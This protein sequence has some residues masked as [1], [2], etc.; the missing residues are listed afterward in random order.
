MTEKSEIRKQLHDTALKAPS[1]S[2]VYLWR[3]TEGVIIYVGKAKNLKSRLT[4]YFSERNNVKTMLL[5]ANALSIEYITTNNEFDA[6][7]LE[8]NLI[9]Q[10]KPRYNINLKDDK[11]YPSLRITREEFPRIFS[12]RRILRDGSR[13]FG[14]FPNAGALAAFIEALSRTYPL[15]RCRQLRKRESPCMYYHIGSCRAPCCGKINKEAYTEF[16]EE[17]AALLE[18][19]GKKTGKKLEAAMKEAAKSLNFEKAARLRD[20]INAMGF[21]KTGNAVQ[22]FDLDDRDYVSWAAEG[23]LVSFTVLKVR[24]GKLVGRD[25]YR[26]R[27]LSD[28]ADL[29]P[30]FLGA[31]YTGEAEIPP[32]LF[33]PEGNDVALLHSWFTEICNAKPD[34]RCVTPGMADGSRHEAALNMTT[35]NAK[36]DIARR[37][38]EQGD[39]PAM[40]E[41]RRLLN[42]PVL[43]VRIEGFDIAHIGGDLPVASLISFYN[44]NPDKKNYRYFRLKT[45]EGIIDDFA[46]LREAVSRRY[47]RL[48][49][50]QAEFPDL[51]LVDGGIGQVNAV[52]GVLA[53]LKLNIPIVGLAKRDEELYLPGNS[54]PLTVPKRSDALRLLQRVRD[55]THR[56]A[57]SKNQALRTK[58]KIAEMTG[59][60]VQGKKSGA[61]VR[62]N[63]GKPAG[64]LAASLA[65]T[66]LAE[67]ETGK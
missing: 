30:E 31:Y 8:N 63:P 39:A 25:V 56:F 40:E 65:Q 2:G 64:S 4:S 44:G 14:P 29:I 17:I 1:S 9:K 6:L 59:K 22:G 55:E 58:E 49:N 45:T 61:A 48:L 26:T 13:Y 15:R 46:S 38:R 67:Q 21:L 7:I 5:V 18:D 54:V 50:E 57:T 16:I 60:A 27:S 51:I 62:P 36:E 34:I 33:I 19:K 35:Q 52:A 32:K 47:T 20:G 37:V 23:E 11:S 66:A 24:G 43:P 10:H 53:A 3:N 12:T 28:E 41:L 42:L